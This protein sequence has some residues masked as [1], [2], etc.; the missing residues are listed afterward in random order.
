MTYLYIALGWLIGAAI[1]GVATGR[2]L[3]AV[4]EDAEKLHKRELRNIQRLAR[5]RG[6]VVGGQA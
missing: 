6:T 5:K 4:D 2:F 1:I 3:K